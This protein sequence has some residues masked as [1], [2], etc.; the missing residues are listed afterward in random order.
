MNQPNLGVV[1]EVLPVFHVAEEK[2]HQDVNRARHHPSLA[3]AGLRMTPRLA[4]DI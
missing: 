1:V 3:E 2:T 4:A